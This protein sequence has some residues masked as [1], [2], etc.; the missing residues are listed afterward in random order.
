MIEAVAIQM[1]EHLGFEPWELYAARA[2]AKHRAY[3]QNFHPLER[4]PDRG[5]GRSTREALRALAECRVRSI[6]TIHVMGDRFDFQ[7]VRQLTFDLNLRVRIVNGDLDSS[8]GMSGKILVHWDHHAASLELQRR[9]RGV[10]SPHT[11]W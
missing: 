4:D 8:R 3:M 7:R 2:R 1:R 9:V 6:G 11:G 5:T 10:Q